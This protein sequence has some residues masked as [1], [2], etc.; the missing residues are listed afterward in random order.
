[1]GKGISEILTYAVGVAISPV[2][3]IAVTLMLFSQRARVNGLMFLLGWVLAL[4]V[5]SG[6]AYAAADQANAATDSTTSDTIAWGK[7]VFGILFLLLAVRNWRTRPAPGAEPEMPKWMAGIDALKPGKALGLGLL[8]AG[9]NPKNL[10]LAAAAGA[11]LAALGLSSANAIGSL[12][13]FPLR[14]TVHGD[15]GDRADRVP[16]AFRQGC[17]WGGTRVLRSDEYAQGPRA[18]CELQGRLELECLAVNAGGDWLVGTHFERWRGPL[19][20]ALLT[21]APRACTEDRDA[22]HPGV[23]ARAC[24]GAR[25]PGRVGT[26]RLRRARPRWCCARG[27]RRR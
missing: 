13:A 7:I 1:M 22:E 20:H 21:P 3:I 14:R 19:L 15:V 17:G 18:G 11:G 4:A 23:Q 12:I 16:R 2:P 24:A 6:V 26:G 9:V 27:R 25:A 10:M 8:L 5:V